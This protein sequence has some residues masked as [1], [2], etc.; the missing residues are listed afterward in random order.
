MITPV[1]PGRVYQHY[2]GDYYLVVDVACH[3]E[4]DE[5][6]VIYRALYGDGVL[7]CRPWDSFTGTTTDGRTRFQLLSLSSQK[8]ED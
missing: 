2:K 7:Y 1:I 5:K 8:K 3:T 6:M 4:T